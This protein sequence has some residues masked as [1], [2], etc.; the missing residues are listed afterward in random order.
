MLQQYRPLDG[1]RIAVP[2][3]VLGIE[4]ADD[5]TR[6]NLR[7]A[8]TGIAP[9]GKVFGVTLPKVIGQTAASGDKLALCLGPDEW[10]LMA[11]LDERDRIEAAFA[12]LYAKVPHSLVDISHREV[13]I[14]VEGSAAAVALCSACPLDLDEMPVGAAT[15]TIFD[16]AQIVLIRQGRDSFRIEVWQSFADHVWGILQAA[17]REITLEI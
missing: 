2:D 13:G 15:R 6:F 5:C 8:G 17:G 12:A 10:Q 1:S 9:A 14:V 3:S 4:M 7:I 11:P 16:K